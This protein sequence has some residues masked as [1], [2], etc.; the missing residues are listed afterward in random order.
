M[1]IK[2]VKAL[3]KIFKEEGLS[4]LKVS[5]EEGL[6]HIEKNHESSG[7]PPE[8]NTSKNKGAEPSEKESSELFEIK[9]EQVG[10]FYTNKEDDDDEPFVKVGDY[11]KK[12]DTVG[13]IEAMK[14][15]NEVTSE[16]EGTIE[17]ILVD[18]GDVI[19]YDQVIMMVK[20]EG[21]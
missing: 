9:A 15:F 3:V 6:V 19:E 16:Q 1:D 17:E 20:P 18:S 13:L 5:G 12:G 4:K 8:V 14:V 11:V 21:D 2:N 10:T 7:E